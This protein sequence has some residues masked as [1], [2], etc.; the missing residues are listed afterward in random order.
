M[1][2]IDLVDQNITDTP[3][4]GHELSLVLSFAPVRNHKEKSAQPDN[5]PVSK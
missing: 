1:Y 4:M 2:S 5:N 3:V